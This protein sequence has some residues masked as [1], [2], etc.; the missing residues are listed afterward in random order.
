VFGFDYEHTQHAVPLFQRLQ[1]YR[2]RR[3][4]QEYIEALFRSISPSAEN[5][6]YLSL[7]VAAFLG[8]DLEEIAASMKDEECLCRA[9]CRCKVQTVRKYI[10]ANNP[11]R[12]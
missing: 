7:L 6:V 1:T 9:R 3:V 4:Y 11:R 10:G 12:C 8:D 2:P 5:V